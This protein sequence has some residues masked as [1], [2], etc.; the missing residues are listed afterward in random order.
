MPDRR[1]CKTQSPTQSTPETATGHVNTTTTTV[2]ATCTEDGSVTV[3]CAC[4]EIVSEETIKASGHTE[5]TVPGK[6]ATCTETGLTDGKKCSV[7]GETLLAQET[8]PATGHKFDNDADKDCNNGCGLERAVT[9][10]G[11]HYTK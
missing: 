3:K 8:I 5:E 1:A 4:G 7:C 11:V 10:N 2:D 6:A 9:I